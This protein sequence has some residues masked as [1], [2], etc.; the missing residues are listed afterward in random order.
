MLPACAFGLCVT[1]VCALFLVGYPQP[2]ESIFVLSSFAAGHTV[3]CVIMPL[4]VFQTKN[5]LQESIRPIL[6][7]Y[8]Y[9]T[10]LNWKISIYQGKGEISSTTEDCYMASHENA[11]EKICRRTREFGRREL[12]MNKVCM[13]NWIW[14]YFNISHWTFL[15]CV[16]FIAMWINMAMVWIAH[17]AVIEAGQINDKDA[18]EDKEQLEAIESEERT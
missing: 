5:N 17:E 10:F 6:P 13:N 3:T 12:G 11:H 18:G 8:D 1:R 15:I 2:S 16:P 7:Y 14:G 4:S 9:L